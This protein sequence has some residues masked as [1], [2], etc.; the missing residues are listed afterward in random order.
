VVTVTY[1]SN[2]IQNGSPDGMA[3]V[4]PGG[5]V[6]FLSYEGSFTAVG[7]AAAGFGSS[8]ILVSEVGTEPVGRSLQRNAAGA[9]A[10]P[11]LASFGACNGGAPPPAVN[12]ITFAGRTSSDPPL[13]VGFQDQ[14]F[15]TLRAPDGSAIPTTITWTSETPALASIDQLG[16][17][18]AL[19]AGTAI[20]RATASDAAHTTATIALPT[21]VATASATASY[22]GNTEF[23][24]PAD[25]S[26]ADDFL[27]HYPFYTASFNPVRGIPNWVS[28]DLE[29]THFGP[30]DRCDCFTYD[31]TL[32][33][34]FTRY[35]TADYT[36]AGA[37]H[38]YGIDRGHLARSF[39]RTS[40][41]LDN[42][43]TFYFTNIVPQAA[44]NNQGPWAALETFLGDLARFQNKEVY[45]IAG[46]SGSKGTVK[47]EGRI[48]I[49]ATTW[50]VAVILPRDQGLD[51]IDDYQDL[52]VVAVIIPNN[53]GI[54]NVPWQ[55][56]E[57][58]VDA[59][60]ALSGYDLLALLRDDIE[61]AVESGTAPPSAATDGPYQG[62]VNEAIAMSGA[63]SSDPDGDALT[64]AW[65]FGDGTTATGVSVSHAYAAGGNYQVR[66][67]VTDVLGLADTVFT[68]VSV[69]TA[70]EAADSAGKLVGDLLKAGKL[71]QGNANALSSKLEAAA[72][73]FAKGK[74]GAGVNQLEALLHQ[75]DALEQSGRIAAADT[76]EL[77]ELVGR[78]ITSASSPA[79]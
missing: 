77:R 76:A 30:L 10:A 61:I 23:G 67:I 11:A 51:D 12:F 70:A 53:P 65:S 60:E 18:T 71:N 16:V 47:D 64:Y 14:L 78:I 13:P 58:T 27:V 63:G 43:F 56:Y 33:A 37:F 38:G 24:E 35:T 44:D 75:L 25:G 1:P 2:G 49:P 42:A 66:L 41:S 32:P 40:G 69:L 9:W 26:P 29:A 79:S 19:T 62:L 48:T 74:A 46:A 55:S 17:L 4:S 50:K 15:A 3:L 7:G 20:L 6:E 59:V 21:Q 31:N 22:L 39:D 8:D 45:I 57:T 73:S 52:E 34:S 5:V 36:G 54:R 72:A 68:T 28:Y